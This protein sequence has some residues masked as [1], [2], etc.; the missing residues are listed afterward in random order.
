MKNYNYTKIHRHCG[1]HEKEIKKSKICGCFSCL[2]IYSAAEI[3]EW[4]DEPEDC[5]RGAGKTAVCPNCGID[6]VLPESNDYKITQS[7]INDMGKEFFGS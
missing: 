7:F 5:P 2:K 6:A 4:I 3:V 1:W